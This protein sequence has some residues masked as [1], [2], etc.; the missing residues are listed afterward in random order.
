MRCHH[1]HGL[2]PRLADSVL[3][4][5]PGGG[6]RQPSYGQ[7]GASGLA[8]LDHTSWVGGRGWRMGF[9]ETPAP[10]AQLQVER[11]L[12]S[13]SGAP[14]PASVRVPTTLIMRARVLSPEEE[15]ASERFSREQWGPWALPLAWPGPTKWGDSQK[16]RP[17]ALGHQQGRS[18][19]P[20]LHPPRVTLQGELEGGV[21]RGLTWEMRQPR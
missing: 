2:G 17:R 15:T 5:P 21:I 20:L 6:S 9:G 3:P 4:C 16:R 18:C 13:E 12:G 11:E 1:P 14:S 10:R 7:P 8:R 19:P